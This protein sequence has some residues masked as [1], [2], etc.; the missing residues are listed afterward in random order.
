MD[1]VTLTAPAVNASRPGDVNLPTEAAEWRPIPG[2]P[3]YSVSAIGEVRRN[4]PGHCTFIGRMLKPMQNQTT[5]YFAVVLS[6]NSNPVRID[7]HRLVALAF[8]GPQP[9]SKH[10]VA[11]NDGSRTNNRVENLRW[12]TQKEN[13]QDCRAHGTALLG[14]ANPL[15]RLTEIDIRAIR[16]M[17]TFGVPRD[18]IAEGFGLHKR[19][20][21]RILAGQAWG[22]V[23]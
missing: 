1:I 21:F 22:H 3:E 5:K 16:R 23:Q 13:L 9:S 19:S 8:L 12:A 10:L 17:K 4:T 15:A 11:H 2:W 6:R 14:T 20:V 7:I 18:M